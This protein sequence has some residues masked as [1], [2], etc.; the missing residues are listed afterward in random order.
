LE[1]A[2]VKLVEAAKGQGIELK[3]TYDKEGQLLS[4]KAGRYAHA[5]Q[6][7][8]MNKVL[9]RQNTILGRLQHEITRKMTPLSLAVQ[10]T[11]GHTLHK[12]KRLITQTRS[13][14][15]KD[16]TKDKQPR[17]YS[18][19]APEVEC[20]SKGKS[21]NPYEFGVKVGIGTTLN[22]TLIVG[23][24]IFPSNPYQGYTL[25]EQVE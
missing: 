14:K 16:K 4:Y 8:R 20:I 17:L 22:A 12:A 5:R 1:T 25:N 7:K 2:R 11:L 13:H 19:H 21:R 3:Q 23:V 18:W 24:R 10:E 6:F 15:S 9:K